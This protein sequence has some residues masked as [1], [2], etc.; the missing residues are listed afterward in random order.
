MT[1]AAALT[2]LW[3]YA[4]FAVGPLAII[5]VNSFRPTAEIIR[6]PLGWPDTFSLDNY[7]KALT[8]GHLARYAA[9][10]AVVTGISVVAVVL[11]CTLAAYAIARWQL[12]GASLV[13]LLFLSGLMLPIRYTVL[14]LFYELN[15]MGLINTHLGLIL[16][17]VASGIPFSTFVLVPFVK[18][19]PIEC[20]ESAMLDGAGP[21]RIF[22]QVV[23]PLLV[24]AIVV[25]VIFNFLPLWNEFFYPLVLLRDPDLFTVSVGLTAFI[26]RYSAD[27]GPLFAALVL[28]SLPLVI[29][30]LASTRKIIDGIAEG[31]A[32]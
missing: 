20:E 2:V 11:L 27:L 1:H 22:F 5:L 14:P 21:L 32:K 9:N 28:V 7:A 10:S 12:P 30:F 19:L 6:S 8:Q 3:A 25:V 18:G 24:P 23:L 17:Y 13:L 15:D 4:A 16:I 29:V 31:I 26:G